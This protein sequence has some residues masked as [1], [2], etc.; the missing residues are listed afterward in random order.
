MPVLYK[1]CSFAAKFHKL[2]SDT[3]A[4]FLPGA[5]QIFQRQKKGKLCRRFKQLVQRVTRHP[6]INAAGHHFCST[7]AQKKHGCPMWK[8]E[9]LADLPESILNLAHVSWCFEST[10]IVSTRSIERA[11]I[12][13]VADFF[14]HKRKYQK[15][16]MQGL[17]TY[18]KYIDG[19]ILSRN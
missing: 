9:S 3:L 1:A 10:F 11:T 18:T 8:K 16:R 19:T 6:L 14:V 2:R 15:R 5:P 13:Q 17:G 12:P 7:R 4:D